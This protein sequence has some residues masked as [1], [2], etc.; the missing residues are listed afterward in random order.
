[1]H[2]Q[3]AAIEFVMYSIPHHVKDDMWTLIRFEPYL[4]LN[5]IKIYIVTLEVEH[6]QHQQPSR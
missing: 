1:M 3:G 6:I 2:E 4:L 5:K